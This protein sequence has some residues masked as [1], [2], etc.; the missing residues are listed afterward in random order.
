M[1]MLYSKEGNLHEVIKYL[2]NPPNNEIDLEY[3][4]DNGFTALAL[5]VKNQHLDIISCLIAKGANVI[6]LNKVN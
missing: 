4:N 3:K 1:L 5:A 6:S 2:E